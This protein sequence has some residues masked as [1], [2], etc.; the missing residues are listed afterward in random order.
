MRSGS[1]MRLVGDCIALGM[2]ESSDQISVFAILTREEMAEDPK[3]KLKNHRCFASA[4]GAYQQAG[5][6][7]AV[8]QA[9]LLFFVLQSCTHGFAEPPA[10]RTLFQRQEETR[11]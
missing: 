8:L 9:G 11:R 3:H 7:S 5:S 2:A 1:P 6:L 4:A 10:R